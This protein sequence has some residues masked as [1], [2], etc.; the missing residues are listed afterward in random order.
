MSSANAIYIKFSEVLRRNIEYFR[1]NQFRTDVESYS[2]LVGYL[3]DYDELKASNAPIFNL[4]VDGVRDQ[5]LDEKQRSRLK[6][7]GLI[8]NEN[9]SMPLDFSEKGRFFQ[10]LLKNDA[11]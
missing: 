1:E 8:G 7:E 11:K 6:E 2:V 4:F 10:T 3:N 9:Q 5:K